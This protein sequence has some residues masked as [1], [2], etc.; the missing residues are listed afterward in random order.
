MRWSCGD[1]M[2]KTLKI[3]EDTPHLVLCEGVDAYYF[4]MWFF[5]FMKQQDTKFSQFRVYNFGGISELT[6][7]LKII[8]KLDKFSSVVKSI[9][10]IRD[11]ET[12]ASS[13]TQSIQTSFQTRDFAIPNAPH[14]K[15]VGNGRY[16]NVATGF[17]LFPD[18]NGSPQNG[19]LEDLCLRILKNDDATSVLEQADRALQQYKSQLSCLHK[20]RLHTYFS[21]TNDYV[22][23]KIGE[24]ARCHAFSYDGTEITSLKEFLLKMH[25]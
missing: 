11:A 16:P 7:Y 8:S 9:S 12:N 17:V 25:S 19:T 2:E 15:A 21:F 3:Y 14:C 4:L 10:I 20:N 5:V 13:A 23:L 6:Q 1:S 24:A 22:S 18:L